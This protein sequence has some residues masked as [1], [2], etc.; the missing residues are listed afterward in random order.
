MSWKDAVLELAKAMEEEAAD[1]KGADNRHELLYFIKSLQGHA[2]SLRGIVNAAPD[3]VALGPNPI[4]NYGFGPTI[5]SPYG[6]PES[7]HALEIEKAK[8]E[9]RKPGKE[10]MNLIEMHEG[11]DM[12]E[13]VGGPACPDNAPTYQA[14]DPAMPDQA[15]ML[16]VGAVY[17]LHVSAG[18]R[19]QLVFDEVETQ[20]LAAKKEG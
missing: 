6:G 15:R 7:Q 8:A 16:L 2:R 17:Q 10:K 3:P 9:F 4:P 14:V 5:I 20:R 12:V 13:V 11:G 1:L 19:R 18:G